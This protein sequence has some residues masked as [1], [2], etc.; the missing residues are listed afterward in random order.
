MALPDRSS[1]DMPET[2]EARRAGDEA[3]IV[4]A[5]RLLP[6]GATC[7]VGIGL[8]SAAAILAQRLAAPRIV[9]V[10]E[11]GT[12]GAHPARLPLSVADDTLADNA[13][14]IVGVPE[15]FNYWLQPG[16]IDVGLLGAGQVD[17]FANLNSTTVGGTYPH[18]VV[19]LPGAG[20]APEIASACSRTLV[21]V[22]QN[23]RS[24]VET[25]D[26]VSTVGHRTAGRTRGELGLPGGGPAAVITDIG[27]YEPDPATG[28]LVLARLQPGRTVDEAKAATGWSLAVAADVGSLKAPRPAELEIVR[29]LYAG[30]GR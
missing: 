8:P 13:L 14:T 28:E 30:G 2:T 23:R 26:F 10:Y 5:S 19:R 22:R 12:L 7:F 17:R 27:V 6:D 11:S 29:H 24:F 20:G 18:P 25:V 16:R 1:D 3:M 15:L 21:M 9:L 4:A